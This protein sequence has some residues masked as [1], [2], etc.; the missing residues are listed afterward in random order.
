MINA[1]RSRRF[2]VIAG[3]TSIVLL[4]T[5]CGLLGG[6]SD[7]DAVTA[8]GA[9]FL[10]DWAAGRYAEA[11]AHTTDPAKAEELLRK[12][13]DTLRVGGRSFRPG[14]LSGCK[15]D[16]PCVLP[17][18]ATLSLTALGD[19]SYPGALTLKENP[20]GS[21]SA[22]AWLVDWTPAVVHPKLT[23]DSA[24]SRVR[25]LP[26]RAEILDRDGEALVTDQEVLRVGVVA[27]KIAE[28][29]LK[30]LSELL[31]LNYDALAAAEPEHTGRPVRRG[32]G[33]TAGGVPGRRAEAERHQGCPVAKR[34]APPRPDPAVRP[35]RARHRRPG[36]EGNAGEGRAHGLQ[37]RRHRFVRSSGRL[38]AATGRATRRPGRTRQSRRPLGAGDPAR[39]RAG[40]RHPLA[41]LPGQAGAGRRRT[42]AV[43]DHRE[44]LAGGHRHRD[45]RD[46]RRRQQPGGSRGRGP[47][48]RRPLPARLHLQSHH[49]H[50]AAARG[51][52]AVRHGPLPVDHQRR[53]QELRELR[54]PRVAGLGA[55]Q[56]GFHRV[57]QHRLHLQ[58]QGP[59]AGRPDEG[60]DLLRYRRCVGRRDER[61]LR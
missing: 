58:G 39:V 24:L 38:S 25:E 21:D 7:D 10:D 23:T 34:H 33:P 17:F 44:R 46:S 19:W 12:V 26:P 2:R 30:K 31:D 57:L 60:G 35:R 59:G 40:G 11:A 49:D 8:T 14:A 42:R 55:V 53:R 15:D 16:Q 51:A 5:G 54:R 9:A 50:R 32:G 48:P 3:S 13:Q 22:R 47:R 27:G 61:L 37:C 29:D 56:Q 18:D 4:L 20:D 52:E 1:R 36:D 45:R 6:G 41:G 43:V 28:A